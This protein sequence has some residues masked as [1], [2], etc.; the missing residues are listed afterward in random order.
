MEKPEGDPTRDEIIDSYIKTLAMVVGRS[1]FV[2]I[3]CIESVGLP[4]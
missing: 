4:R 1:S 2:L 3:D